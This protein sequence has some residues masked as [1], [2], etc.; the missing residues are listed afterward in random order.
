MKSGPQS[1]EFQS[2]F[3]LSNPE[4]VGAI[5]AS[6]SSVQLPD[7]IQF[8]EDQPRSMYSFF[9]SGPSC[10]CSNEEHKEMYARN[11]KFIDCKF[12]TPQFCLPFQAVN[13]IK[14]GD[15]EII[16]KQDPS[17]LREYL[18]TSVHPRSFSLMFILINIC[19]LPNDDYKAWMALLWNCGISQLEYDTFFGPDRLSEEKNLF[20]E[21]SGMRAGTIAASEIL[22]QSCSDIPVWVWYK[23]VMATTTASQHH[24]IVD[25][26][27]FHNFIAAYRLAKVKKDKSA[28]EL[29]ANR[30][31]VTPE[32]VRG[33][34]ILNVPM[35]PIFMKGLLEH[36]MWDC[37]IKYCFAFSVVHRVTEITELVLHKL[38]KEYRRGSSAIEHF[39]RKM[40]IDGYI[41]GAYVADFKKV[42]AQLMETFNQ[43]H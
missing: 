23:A 29:L 43:I 26:G 4:Y 3:R 13:L 27:M 33:P 12:L 34:K 30:T 17:L 39:C 2:F 36:P 15:A 6:D 42:T 21:D 11:N 37:Y 24:P 31:L 10:H 16:Q 19:Q 35:D 20:L 8:T 9:S 7:T 18:D 22:Y 14:H 1:S 25:Q 28:M 38:L 40:L 41:P 5:M 32:W